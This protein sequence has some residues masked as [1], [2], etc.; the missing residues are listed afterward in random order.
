MIW[1]FSQIT[2][3]E[4]MS[5]ETGHSQKPYANPLGIVMGLLIL[6]AVSGGL[7]W[8]AFKVFHVGVEPGG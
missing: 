4:P 1:L 3:G 5:E 7:V 6:W 8:L 2:R